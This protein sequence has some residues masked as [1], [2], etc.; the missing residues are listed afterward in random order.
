MIDGYYN[1]IIAEQWYHIG[2]WKYLLQLLNMHHLTV[3]QM[4]SDGT[5]FTKLFTSSGSVR[6]ALVLFSVVKPAYNKVNHP[7][8][9]KSMLY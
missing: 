8:L 5:P 9:T 3:F 4:L 2:A 6:Y 7:Y 1:T